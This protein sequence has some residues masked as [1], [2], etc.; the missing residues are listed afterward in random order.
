M[1]L[2]GA[3]EE[4]SVL[5]W[6][7]LAGMLGSIAFVLA[8]PVVIAFGNW[9]PDPPD[10]EA[11]VIRFPD[12]RLGT[13]V[14]NSVYL[15]AL[16]LWVISFLAL[17]RALRGTSL[18]PALSGSVLGIVG[19]AILA[20]GA[21]THVAV[22][23]I[24]DLYHAS[25]ATPAD[26]ATLVLL[27][28]ATQGMFDAMFTVGLLLVL[29]RSAYPRSGRARG[30]GLWQGLWRGERGARGGRGRSGICP[31][32]RSTFSNRVRRRSRARRLPSR[33]GMEGLQ[34]VKGRIGILED[35]GRGDPPR[36]GRKHR[37]SRHSSAVGGVQIRVC[38]TNCY[39]DLVCRA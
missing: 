38:H 21:L 29:I 32:G 1:S 30:P 33:P 24:S 2:I 3:T 18:A 12:A 17:Y 36:R 26:Q 8:F 28:Q 22:D 14:E 27:W 11:L 4:K 39:A 25:G 34:S 10:P 23:P 7:G 15:A 35:E 37:S 20:T 6:G 13:I 9:P 31:C 19:L 5:R 16:V